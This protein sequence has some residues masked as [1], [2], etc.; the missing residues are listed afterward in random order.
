MSTSL[1]AS[2]ADAP[3]QLHEITAAIQALK[4]EAAAVLYQLGLL[5]RQVDERELWRAGGFSSLTDYLEREVDVAPTTAR[6]AI[7]VARHFNE[8]I[9]TRYGFDKLSKGMRHPSAPS[10]QRAGSR[11]PRPARE[12]SC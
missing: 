7:Q 6:R 2:A 12:R 10:P 3:A 1:S 8:E 11:R 5:L 4:G 9:A